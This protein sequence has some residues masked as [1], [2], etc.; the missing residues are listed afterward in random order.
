MVHCHNCGTDL[1]CDDCCE[2]EDNAAEL[3]NRGRQLQELVNKMADLFP[4]FV[5][6]VHFL[7]A[8]DFEDNI[9]KI[10]S[11]VEKAR[12]LKGN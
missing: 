9:E 6:S 2:R 5:K 3:A 10:W 12:E 11:V 1:E 7:E 8:S 4:P